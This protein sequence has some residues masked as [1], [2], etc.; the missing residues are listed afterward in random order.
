MRRTGSPKSA[1]AILPHGRAAGRGSSAS[2]HG[3]PVLSQEMRSPRGLSVREDSKFNS[4]K[5][6]F[7]RREKLENLQVS[8]AEVVSP[9]L[10]L[11]WSGGSKPAL[12]EMYECSNPAGPARRD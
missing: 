9:S 4:L 7:P 1:L 12:A 10:V 3:S 8:E 11:S 5:K 6:K 2:W